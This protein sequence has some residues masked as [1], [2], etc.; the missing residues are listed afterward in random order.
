M[1]TKGLL[2]VALLA[3]LPALA[4]SSGV[5]AGLITTPSGEA[6]CNTPIVLVDFNRGI[7]RQGSTGE[8]GIFAF[9]LLPAGEYRLE[10][11]AA[12]PVPMGTETILLKENEKR[13]WRVIWGAAAV[14]AVRT[15]DR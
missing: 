6:I 15:R 10:P 4:Q 1:H 12:G 5:L 14:S 2:L 3:V 11:A 8:L 13:S 7:R 9:S